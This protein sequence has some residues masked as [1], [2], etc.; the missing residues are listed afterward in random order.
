MDGLSYANIVPDGVQDMLLAIRDRER[1][2][3]FAVGDLTQ[4]V[5][6]DCD[7]RC[8]EVTKEDVYKAVASFVGK[9]SR[10]VREYHMVAMK[11]NVSVRDTY[12]LLAFNHFRVALRFGD[13]CYEALSWAE[14]QVLQLGRPATVDAMEAK[15]AN[16]AEPMQEQS[17]AGEEDIQA[18]PDVPDAVQHMQDRERVMLVSF[19]KSIST[20]V[21]RNW[22]RLGLSQPTLSALLEAIK[23]VEG[24]LGVDNG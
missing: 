8:L 24:E 14:D 16:R 13:A 12:P 7:Y 10:T 9:Q 20:I 19:I 22:K 6:I 21:N 17:D 15:F 11:F 18:L 2:D 1:V 3:R 5:T 4:A 23:A